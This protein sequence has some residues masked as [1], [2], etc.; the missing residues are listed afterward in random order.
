MYLITLLVSVER[1]GKDVV[2]SENHD[3]GQVFIN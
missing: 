3:D 1:F 2:A